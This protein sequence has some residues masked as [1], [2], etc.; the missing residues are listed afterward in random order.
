[1]KLSRRTVQLLRV[2]FPA[3]RGGSGATGVEVVHVTVADGDGADGSGF[4]YA[5]T[6]GGSAVAGML[7]DTLLP[8]ATG[9]DLTSWPRT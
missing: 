2:P 5:L 9:S 3:A 6:G 7:S 8:A 4:T 1:M